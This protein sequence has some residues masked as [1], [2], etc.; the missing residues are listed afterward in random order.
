VDLYPVEQKFKTAAF[1]SLLM[2]I[3]AIQVVI[4]ALL[5]LVKGEILI[6]L[7]SLLAGLVFSYIF[8]YFYAKNRL[9]A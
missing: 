2:T 4:Y 5:I 3:L 9:K 7:L 8:V 6:S 1:H